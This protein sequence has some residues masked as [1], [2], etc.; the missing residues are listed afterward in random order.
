MSIYKNKQLY[1]LMRQFYKNYYL[2]TLKLSDWEYRFENYRI[3]EESVLGGKV[4]SYLKRQD[5]SLNN[6]KILIV[7]GGTGAE[8]FYINET[9]K[10]SCVYIVEPSKYAIE[11]LNLKASLLNFPL[12]NIEK[13]FAEGL[14]FEDDYFDIVI[15]YTVLEHVQ[16]VEKSIIEMHRVVKSKGVVM[17]ETPNYLFPEEQHYKVIIFPPKISKLLARINLKLRGRYT[18]FF[19]SLN[20]FSAH[21]I[22]Q[23]LIKNGISYIRKDQ[24]YLKCASFK[25]FLRYFPKYVFS[26]VFR[27]SR[28][29]LIFIYKR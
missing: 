23:L 24:I 6:K 15:C 29:Q 27:I 17:I 28:N 22:D 7:G 26:W 2:D 1:N 21:D 12:K 18:N 5:V 19:E 3:E 14:P 25:A 10:D 16:N 4:V 11:I 9:F 20:F 8:A 13:S